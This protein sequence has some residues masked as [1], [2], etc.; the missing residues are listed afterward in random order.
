M[1][2]GCDDCPTRLLRALATNPAPNRSILPV[3]YSRTWRNTLPKRQVV[4]YICIYGPWSYP[5][6]VDGS[7]VCRVARRERVRS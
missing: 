3:G 1:P 4:C 7:C 5:N 2:T 6:R